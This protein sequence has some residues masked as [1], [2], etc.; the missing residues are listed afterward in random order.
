MAAIDLNCDLGESFGVYSYGADPEMMPMITSANIACGAHG[1]D[2][3]VMR[4]SVELAH[5]HGTTVVC[6]THDPLLIEL[7]DEGV[8]ALRQ[9]VREV[10]P[11]LPGAVG[12]RQHAP[13]RRIR[14]PFAQR[15]V[16]RLREMGYPVLT[17]A[18][19]GAAACTA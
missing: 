17:S 4:R 7:A 12:Q 15:D 18:G 19:H 5:D 10:D 9:R 16:E 11:A 3:A 2:P 13:R 14:Q 6:A 1:G 8:T